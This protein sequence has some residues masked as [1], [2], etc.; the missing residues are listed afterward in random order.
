[1]RCIAGACFTHQHVQGVAP[2]GV[3]AQAV[4]A[5]G[6]FAA[7]R[8]LLGREQFGL[9]GEITQRLAGGVYLLGSVVPGAQA[10]G[11]YSVE[12]VANGGGTL[13]NQRHYSGSMHHR[14]IGSDGALKRG[15]QNFTLRLA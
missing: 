5:A 1:M 9:C 2:I 15:R 10:C 11:T 8:I 3:F 12:S 6:Q 13:M 7:K 14:P 4:E